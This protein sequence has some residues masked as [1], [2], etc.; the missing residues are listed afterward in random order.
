M[1][2]PS[3]SNFSVNTNME[4]AF[5]SNYS[6]PATDL[7][8]Q[9]FSCRTYE[10][11]PIR[12]NLRTRLANYASR[13]TVGPLGG[14]ARFQLVAGWEEDLRE[15]RSLGTYGFIKG[16]TGFIVGATG[17]DGKHLEDFGYLLEKIILFATDLGLGTCWIGGTFT[18]TSFARKIEVSEHE[19]VPSV[20]SVG[21]IAKKP[22][23]IDGLIRKGAKADNRLPWEDLFFHNN[24]ENSL[25]RENAGEYAEALEMV[26]LGPSASNHQPWRV[27]KAGEKW[28]FFLKRTPGYNERLLVKLTGMADLQRIDMGIALCHFE[29]TARELGLSGRWVKEEPDIHKPDGNYLYTASWFDGN[30]G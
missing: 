2:Q 10:K 15:L 14:E 16:A 9:R 21:Y 22:R 8:V 3:D 1:E 19:M 7:I 27:V 17:S 11:A 5:N 23:R 28:H 25:K 30:N 4:A 12:E 18:R 20:A 29:L 26:R 6:K 13:T 24:F